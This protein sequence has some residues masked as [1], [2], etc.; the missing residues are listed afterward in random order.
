MKYRV[1][2]VGPDDIVDFDS[3][4]DALREANAINKVYIQQ[5]AAHG[6]ENSVLCV[7]YVYQVSE[8]P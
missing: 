5:G 8:E 2:V 3:E 4:I 1:H 6:W 7:A